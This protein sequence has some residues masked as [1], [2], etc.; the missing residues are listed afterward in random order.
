[1]PLELW[2][3]WVYLGKSVGVLFAWVPSGTG[4]N[5]DDKCMDEGKEKEAFLNI[6][7]KLTLE[8]SGSVQENRLLVWTAILW[9]YTYCLL[10]QHLWR[11]C[12]QTSKR[13]FLAASERMREKGSEG[14]G[15]KSMKSV[16][17]NQVPKLCLAE[18][19][20]LDLNQRHKLVVGCILEVHIELERMMLKWWLIAATQFCSM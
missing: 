9:C 7:G 18:P 2:H 3:Q 17:Q 5:E 8:W 15:K 12:P 4:G 10:S 13:W 20:P 11:T 1:M 6:R 19:M 16:W 14:K